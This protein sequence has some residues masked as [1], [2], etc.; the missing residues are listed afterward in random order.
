MTRIDFTDFI[1]LE[2]PDLLY[3]LEQRNSDYVRCS[4][5]NEQI[6]GR[7]DHLRFCARLKERSDLKYFY[8]TVDAKPFGVSDFKAT[9]SDWCE[10]EGGSYTFGDQALS[11]KKV[12]AIAILWM[13]EH[14]ELKRM[15][16]RIKNNN[17]RA[18]LP[19]Y[20]KP[21]PN[22]RIVGKDEHY[23]YT[24]N[25]FELEA[26]RAYVLTFLGAH[27]AQAYFNGEL[28]LDGTQDLN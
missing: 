13:C 24:Q 1:F 21:H 12:N 3:I 15:R 11:M 18:L 26:L 28:F 22:L 16:A 7:A 8:I 27:Q 17:K 20:L 19:L 5:D 14:H 6:I 9:G 4:M 2:Q 23:T 25:S 10:A